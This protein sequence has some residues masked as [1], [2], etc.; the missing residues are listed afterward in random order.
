MSVAKKNCLPEPDF[1]IGEVGTRIYNAKEGR[2]IEEFTRT[3]SEGWDLNLVEEVMQEL[4]LGQEPQ[5]GNSQNEFKSSWYLDNA[6]LEQISLIRMSLEE[7]GVE[8]NIV[9][10]CLRYLDILPKRANKGHAL[11]WLLARLQIKT[12]ETIVAGDSGNDTAMF[13]LR[14]VKGIVVANAQPELYEITS[15]LPVYHAEGKEVY[16]VL[17]GLEYYGVLK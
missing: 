4:N 13:L 5:P 11:F 12:E 14:G 7:V 3:L 15:H 17:E 16:G 6:N 2:D 10:S 1:I 9:Y 8:A